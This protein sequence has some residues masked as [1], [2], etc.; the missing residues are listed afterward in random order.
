VQIIRAIKYLY[1][2]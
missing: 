1:K 2:L